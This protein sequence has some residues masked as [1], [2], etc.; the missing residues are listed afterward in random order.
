MET[1]EQNEQW[2]E[3]EWLKMKDK[4]LQYATEI[5]LAM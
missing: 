3:E 1:K 4:L 5:G 2:F